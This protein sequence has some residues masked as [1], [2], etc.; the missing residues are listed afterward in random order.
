[1]LNVL[2]MWTFE[3]SRQEAFVGS[4]VMLNKYKDTRLTEIG[5]L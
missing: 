4:K 2:H 1:M 5:T 3:T